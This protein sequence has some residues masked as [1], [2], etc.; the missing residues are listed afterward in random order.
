MRIPLMV[1]GVSRV[2]VS[3]QA[4]P[5]TR[6]PALEYQQESTDLSPAR[7]PL[8][9]PS[10]QTSSAAP[11][12]AAADVLA[13]RARD[14]DP[15]AFSALVELMQ[16]RALRFAAQMSGASRDDVEDIV[17]DAWIRT[18]RAL[19]RYDA[20]RPFE[21]WY[22]HDPRQLLPFASG[23]PAPLAAAQPAGG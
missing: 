5:V 18:H 17:Q 16:P 4:H 15:G 8:P 19:H 11:P 12:P 22:L 7:M 20:S 9:R 23:T 6:T 21:S 10:L 3:R 13:L 2:S 1:P 14:G